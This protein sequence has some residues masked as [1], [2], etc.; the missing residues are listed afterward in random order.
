MSKTIKWL[1]LSI[2]LQKGKNNNVWG[3]VDIFI[4]EDF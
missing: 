2:G 4:N 3:M 1:E